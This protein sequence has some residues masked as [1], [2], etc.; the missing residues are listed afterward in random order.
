MSLRDRIK[1]R[2]KKHR[3]SEKRMQA[4][5]ARKDHA[6]T[7]EAYLVGH[8]KAQEQDYDRNVAPQVEK[9]SLEQQVALVRKV[10]VPM[11]VKRK[12][13]LKDLP[14]DIR[15]MATQ[16]KTGEEIKQHFWGCEAFRKL[17]QDFELQ[18]ATL[19]TMIK[20]AK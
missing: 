7:R 20:E 19:D 1:R 2:N 18:E 8:R 6:K 5:M 12:G 4:E 9:M 11:A 10:R 3:Q 14:S 16:G 15:R 17:W 13:I